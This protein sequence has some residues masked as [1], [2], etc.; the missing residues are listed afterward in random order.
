M[1]VEVDGVTA[2]PEGLA[3]PLHLDLAELQDR[4]HAV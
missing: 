4:P 2:Q 1:H 3:N